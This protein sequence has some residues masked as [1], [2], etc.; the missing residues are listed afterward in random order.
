MANGLRGIE[1]DSDTEIPLS[2]VNV[3]RNGISDSIFLSVCSMES[4]VDSTL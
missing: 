2:A 1:G 3:P 4:I